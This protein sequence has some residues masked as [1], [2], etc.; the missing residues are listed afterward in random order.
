MYNKAETANTKVVSCRNVLM[1]RFL[2]RSLALD[3]SAPS[4][5]LL[6]LLF[7][8]FSERTKFLAA[9]ISF[10][11][12]CN[13]QYASS[14]KKCSSWTTVGAKSCTG[15]ELHHSPGFTHEIGAVD[16]AACRD[17]FLL[18]MHALPRCR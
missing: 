16:Q 13:L 14:P 17:A 15:C 8:R 18:K 6:A 1:I 4:G 9:R 3:P 5:G 2:L 11:T 12:L 10:R 7:F